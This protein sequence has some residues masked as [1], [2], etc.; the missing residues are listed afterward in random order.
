MD[1]VV[2]SPELRGVGLACHQRLGGKVG[3]L[4]RSRVPSPANHAYKSFTWH[5]QSFRH[6]PE[7]PV[8]RTPPEP[9]PETRPN[10]TLIT[11]CTKES[12]GSHSPSL[13]FTHSIMWR[14]MRLVRHIHTF[15]IYPLAILRP[16]LH[17]LHARRTPATRPLL[18]GVAR[19]R[20]CARCAQPDGS[21]WSCVEGPRPLEWEKNN[22]DVI[23]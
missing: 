8:P 14:Q 10:E 13:R 5:H 12:S 4:S 22:I 17:G 3:V 9:T 16:L 1:P 15:H 20:G 21:P 23:L 19:R 2:F 18:R 7:T 6:H 11:S